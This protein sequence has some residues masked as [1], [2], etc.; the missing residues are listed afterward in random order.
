MLMFCSRYN[1]SASFCVSL[2][3]SIPSLV[4]TKRKRMSSCSTLSNG[5]S[6]EIAW[7]IRT[8]CTGLIARRSII[9]SQATP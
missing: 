2:T 6:Y 5:T 7:T 9:S 4:Q 1:T 3:L 8:K